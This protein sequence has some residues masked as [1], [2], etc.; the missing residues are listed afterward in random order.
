[1]RRASA[2]GCSTPCASTLPSGSRRP[3]S[4]TPSGCATSTGAWRS[5][6]ST[7]RCRP[8]RGARCTCSKASTTTCAPVSIW[9]LRRDPQAALRLA[10]RLWRFWLDRGYFAEGNRWLQTTLAAAPEQTALRVEALLAGAGL[11]LRLG[12]PDAFLR[13]VSDAVSAYR[14]LGDERATAAALYQHAMLAQFVHRADAEALF[15]EAL[16][17]AHRLQDERL[18][19]VATH[20]SATLPWYRG[21]TATARTRVLAALALLDAAPDDDTPFFDGVTFG[22][23]LLEEGPNR[24]PRMFWEET[25][26]LFHRFARA[27]AIAYALNNLAWVARA[28]GDLERA[29]S[30]LDDAL[31]RFRRLQDRRG[32]A[33]TLAHMGNLARSLGDFEAARARLEQALTLRSELGDRRAMLSTRIGLG[34]L[35]MTT[36]DADAGR[37]LLGA[38]L[39]HTEAVDDLPAMAGVQMNWAIG[40]E[41]LGR[42]GTTA[43]RLYE[44]SCALLGLQRLWRLEAWGRMALHDVCSAAWRPVPRPDG[45]EARTNAVHRRRRRARGRLHG[46]LSRR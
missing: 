26:F 42:A 14:M 17:L 6:S 45:A 31:A 8:A 22:M 16:T 7:T 34:L 39:A 46:T 19:A 35:D 37:A 29:Q 4:A 44:D 43:A 38:A 12:D 18:L 13:H 41:R 9:A 30:T 27:Q 36:G 1:M 25:I 24:R 11:S 21:D 28:D 20:A 40:E 3:P 10:T 32:E 33:L 23:C 5:P 2:S 15:T